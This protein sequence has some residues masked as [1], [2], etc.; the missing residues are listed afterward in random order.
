MSVMA[1]QEQ[2][3]K[4]SPQTPETIDASIWLSINGRRST[5]LFNGDASMTA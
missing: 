4:H 3:F 5:L 2:G 1:F